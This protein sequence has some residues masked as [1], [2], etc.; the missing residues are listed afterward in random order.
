MGRKWNRSVAVLVVSTIVLAACSDS[1]DDDSVDSSPDAPTTD[2]T[3]TTVDDGLPGDGLEVGLLAPAPGLLAGLFRGQVRGTTFAASDIDAGGGVDDGPLT[4][5]EFTAELGDDPSGLVAVAAEADVHQLIGPAG[6]DAA[7]AVRDTAAESGSIACT[8]SA[9]LP[10][11]TQDQDRMNLFRT[12]LPDDVVTSYLT[13]VIVGRQDAA[14]P[15]A[16]W[17]VAIVARSDQ[18]GQSVSTG[19]AATLQAAGM[20]PVVVGYNP[21]RVEFSGTAAQVVA[22]NADLTVLI[23]YEEG[24]NL[25]SSL[26]AAGAD[27]ATMIGLDAFFAPRI[28]AQA[29]PGQD[30][31]AADGFTLLGSMG[32][33]AFLDRLYD[34]DSNGDVAFAAQAYDCAVV[35]ALATTAVDL[36]AADSLPSAVVDVTGGGTTCTTYADCLDKLTSGEDI[37]YDGA[38]GQLAL[39]DRGDPTFARF[40]TA[41]LAG[42]AITNVSSSDVDIAQLRRQ[43]E[44]YNSAALITQIQQAL[45]FLGFYAGPINGLDTEEFRTA[46]AAFQASVGLPAT[47]V[48]DAATDAALRQALGPYADLLMATTEDIQRML[49]DLGFYSGPIDGVWSNELSDAIRALQREL[50]VP[51]TGVLD[52]ATV[53]AAYERGAQD[54]TTTTTTTVPDTT[55]PPTTVPPTTVP[56]TTTPPTT[57]PT[58]V[59]PPDPDDPTLWEVLADD[60]DNFSMFLELLTAAGFGPDF[61]TLRSYTVFV[62]TNDAFMASMTAAQFDELMARTHEELNALLT[63]YLVEGSVLVAGMTG[64]LESVHG[65]PILVTGSGASILVNGVPITVPDRVASNGVIQGI[66]GLFPPP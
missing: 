43:L 14:A 9:S 66:G 7:E 60:P 39:D 10:R 19:L 29:T 32:N 2:G 56:P 35:F 57:P 8:A 12:V 54:A 45:R 41:T 40:T 44:A 1:G 6:S 3:E 47:G 37:D 33:K 28:A 42:G 11:L 64:D 55:V 30:A 18:Y 13:Q 51:E 15:A 16:P 38:S 46:L 34:D 26:L 36:G 65:A 53:R 20:T 4:V 17:T 62:P 59:P 49:T 23:T 63:Y 50:G 22:T 24:A 27:P 58:T 5:T 25:L 48:W 21:R 52:A 31:S 61:E